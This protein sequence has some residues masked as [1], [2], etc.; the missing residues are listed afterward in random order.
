MVVIDITGPKVL[1]PT[2][3]FAILSS[4]LLPDYGNVFIFVLSFWFIINFGF[5][6]TLSRSDL[7]ISGLL[8]FIVSSVMPG[9]MTM[10]TVSIRTFV[11]AIL[12]AL[13][14]CLCPSFF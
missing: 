2:I 3:L 8:F 1:V 13:V 7:I 4:G 11:F 14:R 12:W 9:Q 6:F 5:K 10:T